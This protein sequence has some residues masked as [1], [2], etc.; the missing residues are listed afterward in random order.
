[1]RLWKCGVAL[2]VLALAAACGAGCDVMTRH[3][4]GTAPY[5][6]PAPIKV[7]VIHDSNK[8]KGFKDEHIVD[9]GAGL[10]VRFSGNWMTHPA[11]AD[12]D[13]VVIARA[14]QNTGWGSFMGF[15]GAAFSIITVTVLPGLTEAGAATWIG[16]VHRATPDFPIVGNAQIKLKHTAV[17]WMFMVLGDRRYDVGAVQSMVVADLRSHPRPVAQRAEPAAVDQRQPEA[18]A[19]TTTRSPGEQYADLARKLEAEGR[20]PEAVSP[21]AKAVEY[22]TQAAGAQSKE[23]GVARMDLGTENLLAGQLAPATT[24]LLAAGAALAATAG[25][26]SDEMAKWHQR[27]GRLNFA[28]GRYADAG[29]DYQ[30]ALAIRESLR[31][32]ENER[33]KGATV[34]EQAR[35]AIAQARYAEAQKALDR[36]GELL[37]RHCDGNHPLA[38]QQR[39][40]SSL[41]A[42]AQGNYPAAEKSLKELLDKTRQ[43]LGP[44][45]PEA[46]RQLN[47]LAA[48]Y[49]ARN[50]PETARP[51]LD[52]ALQNQKQLLGDAH[53]D[54]AITDANLAQCNREA[55]RYADAAAGFD[56]ALA[57]QARALGDH[58]PAY[59]ETLDR[60]ARLLLAMGDFSQAG[61]AGRAAQGVIR[62]VFPVNHPWA[63]ANLVTL[64]LVDHKMGRFTD[65]ETKFQEALAAWQGLDWTNA[66][67]PQRHPQIANVRHLLANL[68]AEWGRYADAERL[69]NLAL[70]MERGY[71]GE[72]SLPVVATL[73]TL[74]RVDAAAGEFPKARAALDEVA[75]IQPEALKERTP[76]TAAALAGVAEANAAVGDYARAT[77]NLGEAAAIQRETLGAQ[78]P[79]VAATLT[80]LAKVNMAA[81]DYAQAETNLASAASIQQNEPANPQA[82]QTQQELAALYT[83]TGQYA[84]AGKIY[85]KQ[86][87]AAQQ[88]FGK[89]SVEYSQALLDEGEF[90]GQTY[91]FDAAG[92]ALAQS[93]EIQRKRLPPD[94]PAL[95]DAT[96]QLAQNFEAVGDQ[97]QAEQLYAR[98]LEMQKK[99]L[100]ADHPRTIAT[101]ADLGLHYASL[102]DFKRAEESLAAAL[103]AAERR[104]QSAPGVSP[105]TADLKDDLGLVQFYRGDL[106]GAAKLLTEAAEAR[107]KLFGQDHPLTA[108]SLDHLGMLALARGDT[109]GARRQFES[110]LQTRQKLLGEEHPDTIE[111]HDHLGGLYWRL[112]DRAHAKAEFDLAFANLK[113]HVL[114]NLECGLTG[115]GL[116][117][118]ALVRPQLDRQI[119]FF[120]SGDDAA[121]AYARAAFAKGLH[122]DAA[123]AAREAN[124][125]L[126]EPAV[127]DLLVRY[128]SAV[129]VQSKL[130]NQL[131][132]EP[133]AARRQT[134][135]EYLKGWTENVVALDRELAAKSNR[136][137]RNKAALDLTTAAVQRALPPDA[138]LVDIYRYA[139]SAPG[140][141]AAAGE[142]ADEYLFFVVDKKGVAAAAQPAQNVGRLVERVY[143]EFQSD[144]A[145]A[146]LAGGAGG[147]AAEQEYKNA[148]RALYA[149]VLAPYRD[150]LRAGQLVLVS[151]DSTLATI[152]FEA[153]ADD[154]GEYLVGQY[155]FGYEASAREFVRV[156]G[157]ATA[158]RGA[159]LV[160]DPN[161]GEPPPADAKAAANPLQFGRLEQTGLEVQQVA[162][163]FGA[164]NE[165][166][167][168]AAAQEA[169]VKSQAPGRRFLYFATH[170]YVLTREAAAPATGAA[171]RGIGLAGQLVHGVP[172]AQVVANPLDLC[173]LALADA[174]LPK[175]AD[176]AGDDGLLT[177]LKVTGLNLDS[178]SCAVLSA[179]QTGFGHVRE[180]QGLV[181]LRYAFTLAGAA[182]VL[183]SAWSVP[184]LETRE[185]LQIWTP[186][187]V[188]GEPAGKALQAAKLAEIE[189]V[190]ARYQ[191]THP[192][193]WGAFTASGKVW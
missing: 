191:H 172:L 9:A 150:K 107:A 158:G 7:L 121:A 59:G 120:L 160:G 143:A 33:E 57:L 62:G 153:L 74:A 106:D 151:A 168:G 4:V 53:P 97:A 188:A 15:C 2:V 128:R 43:A 44:N 87:D 114:K 40:M 184:D 52:L 34:L 140:R 67:V 79:A 176:G 64:A 3:V 152:P 65:A 84:E 133:D 29:A 39:E 187:V 177:G 75:Q 58:H 78:S 77:Q 137:V 17:L 37:R 161:F 102:G 118:L 125:L 166:L 22:Y 72:R 98:A 28:L 115:E 48:V 144:R 66:D 164:D 82:A 81:G 180:A 96:R 190:R 89:Q 193:F 8:G 86:A 127:R 138:A 73:T 95:A 46:S 145:A 174:N 110:A 56:Q 18:A 38:I 94:H 55:A 103:A 111:A 93:V 83:V 25:E 24:E 134:L 186:R 154:R 147:A 159:L 189:A 49:L 105:A 142:N 12:Y 108:A 60:R 129:N 13:Y 42:F 90:Y 104:D 54:V 61:E 71:A 88:V 122:F 6:D 100:G 117:F 192:L 85:A 31:G 92:K 50:Q 30:K 16:E 26:N 11:Y 181:G 112:G 175:P 165:I 162:P 99:T 35:L 70:A 179:C 139:P 36:S 183:G 178:V 41:L 45:H 141:N 119:S 163:S 5:S 51:L 170:G 182:S 149:S 68:Y 76:E 130:F 101:Y 19:G 185:L 21:L 173:G 1:M 155:V 113:K 169:R 148:A 109:D 80:Q 136:Y 146:A 131:V 124:A 157:R 47:D 69:L 123:I 167:L 135:N 171:V 63:A 126:G 156:V 20:Y 10:D 27:Q 91:Q 32:N 116:K 132:R 23:V 14:E